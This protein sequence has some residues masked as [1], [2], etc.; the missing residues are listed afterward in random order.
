MRSPGGRECRS[1]P[2]RRRTELPLKSLERLARVVD[3]PEQPQVLR[4]DRAVSN[5][6]VEVHDLLPVVRPVQEDDD[7]PI[8]LVGLRERQ[9]LEQLVQSAESA[10][11]GNHGAREVC[12]PKLPHEEVMELEAELT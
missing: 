3:E 5:Q 2:L 1:V 11:E 9:D 4:R 12:E 10:R 6:R 8:E 7:R